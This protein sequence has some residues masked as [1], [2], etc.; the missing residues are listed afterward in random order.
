MSYTW[1]ANS[2]GNGEIAVD[3]INWARLALPMILIVLL[4]IPR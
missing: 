1:A 4:S 3:P 2:I